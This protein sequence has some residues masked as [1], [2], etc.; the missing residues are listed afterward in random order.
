MEFVHSY[1]SIYIYLDYF[2]FEFIRKKFKKYKK[3]E[4]TGGRNG[5]LRST[6]L[7]PCPFPP[8]IF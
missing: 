2:Q 7:D 8:T 3:R 5:K 1:N 4:G 6:I